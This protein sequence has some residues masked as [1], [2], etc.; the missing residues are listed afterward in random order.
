MLEKIMIVSSASMGEEML[1]SILKSTPYS[2][3]ITA[4]SIFIRLSWKF[5]VIGEYTS[6]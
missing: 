1:G 3:M 2:S 5:K 6:S 4:K